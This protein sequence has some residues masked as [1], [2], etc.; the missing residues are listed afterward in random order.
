MIKL[1]K[2]GVDDVAFMMRL[3]H[4]SET[5]KYVPGLI[6]DPGMMRSWILG[7]GQADHECIVELKEE[8]T[9]IGE[10]SLTMRGGVGEI[11]VMLLSSYWRKGYG[12]EVICRLLERARKCKADEVVA[13]TDIENG[14]M[15]HIMEKKGFQKQRA[16]WMLRMQKDDAEPRGMQTVVQYGMKL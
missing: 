12:T 7:L 9:P 11:G 15:I 8:G 6:D 13:M 5:T 10:C 14:A 4:D 3:V 2:L 1:R 16:G